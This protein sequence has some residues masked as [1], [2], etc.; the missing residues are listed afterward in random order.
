MEVQKKLQCSVFKMLI[1]NLLKIVMEVTSNQRYVLV[2]LLPLRSQF[3]NLIL[4]RDAQDKAL[5]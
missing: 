1:F 5:S 4:I 2:G 3:R